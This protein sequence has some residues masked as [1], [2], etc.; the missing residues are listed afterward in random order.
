MLGQA[1]RARRQAT[2][3]PG[4]GQGKP[5]PGGSPLLARRFVLHRRGRDRGGELPDVEPGPA[6]LRAGPCCPSAPRRSYG[7]LTMAMDQFIKIG[8]LKGEAQ[9]KVH[10]DEIDVLSWSWGLSNSGSAQQGA[11]AGAGKVSVR[12]LNFTKYIDKSSPDL[13]LACCG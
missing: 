6:R 7:R 1:A 3:I 8:S 10:K 2:D 5:A 4:A 13:M 11:G 9:D 12:D